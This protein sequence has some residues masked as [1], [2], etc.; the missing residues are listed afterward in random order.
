MRYDKKEAEKRWID[1]IKR[2]L[3]FSG[4]QSYQIGPLD[5]VIIFDFRGKPLLNLIK[6]NF[7]QQLFNKSPFF[8]SFPL[9]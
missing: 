1:Q 6:L 5:Y 7:L 2:I 4:F 8:G 9:G 3:Y